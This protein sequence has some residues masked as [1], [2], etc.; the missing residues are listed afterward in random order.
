MS[1]YRHWLLSERD[2][3][4]TLALNRPQFMNNLDAETLYELREITAELRS[5]REVWAVI[6]Q[7]RGKHFSA[8]MDVEVIRESLDRSEQANREFLRGLQQCLDDFEALEKP[9]IA[10]LHGFCIGGGLILA[11][12]C[13]FRVAS[14]RTIFSLPEVKLGLGVIMGTQRLTGVVGVALTKEMVLLGKRLNARDAQA[15]GLVHRVVPPDEL[16]AAVARLAAKFRKLPPRTVGI[17]KR[18]INEGQDMSLRESQDL[19]IEAQAELLDS[20][21]LREALDSYLEK[22]EPR[23]TG[24]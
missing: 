10:K 13:D 14:Q 7:G 21:D 11:L 12:C 1:E 3:I 19:E 4:A 16:D 15:C 20:P 8:G 18:I 22:R 23:F 6:V 24:K 9:T 5:R 17:S 2:R